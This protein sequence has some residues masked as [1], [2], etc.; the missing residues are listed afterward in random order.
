[1]PA[2]WRYQGISDTLAAFDALPIEPQERR[3]ELRELVRQAA[4]RHWNHRMSFWLRFCV[5]PQMLLATGPLSI[6]GIFGGAWW[7]FVTMAVIVT[8]AATLM[9]EAALHRTLL[10]KVFFAGTATWALF[11]WTMVTFLFD[12]AGGDMSMASTVALAV[13]GLVS[14]PILVWQARACRFEAREDSNPYDELL[15]T[16][17]MATAAVY[18]GRGRWRSASSKR[19][20]SQALERL[21]VRA[22]L[23]LA[24]RECVD[25]ADRALRR[26]LRTEALRIAETIRKHKKDITIAKSRDDVDAVVTKLINTA[27]AIAKSDRAALLAD[28]PELPSA[29]SRVRAA[30]TRI[31]PGAVLIGASFLLPHLSVLAGNEARAD[32]VQWTLLAIGGTWILS[33]SA[34]AGTRVGDVLG[35]SLPFK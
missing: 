5:T 11:Q 23:C 25:P 19:A 2:Q 24:L 33:A 12:S 30:M 9:R 26:E 17:I 22:R 29:V 21:A 16:A 3:Y 14:T 15:T 18:R 28:A 32:A 7:R 13:L 1:M 20:G 34:D 27:E 4:K 35:R 8:L 10:A 6:I 31:I